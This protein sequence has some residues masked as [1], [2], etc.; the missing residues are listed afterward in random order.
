MS[1]VSH[2]VI[3]GVLEQS[4]NPGQIPVATVKAYTGYNWN[5][6]SFDSGLAIKSVTILGATFLMGWV[7]KQFARRM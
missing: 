5:D 6:G 2:G 7:I 3:T 1:G 4:G